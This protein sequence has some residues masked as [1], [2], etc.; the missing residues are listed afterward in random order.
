MAAVLQKYTGA[1]LFRI[2]PCEDYPD[3]YY[4]CMDLSRQDLLRNVRPMLKNYPDT[5][6]D[7]KVIYWDIQIT[8]VQCR[9]LFFHFLNGSTLQGK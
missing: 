6:E 5:L 4:Q 2:E 3:D 9:H 1:E 7:Y 8:G